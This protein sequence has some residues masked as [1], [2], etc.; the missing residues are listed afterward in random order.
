[1]LKVT[2]QAIFS[3]A[4]VLEIETNTPYYADFEYE[5]YVNHTLYM[6]G[7]KNVF[8]LYR[9]QPDTVY[10]I[11]VSAKDGTQAG[12]CHFKT[13]AESAFLDV[14]RFHA[15]NDGKTECTACL[16]AAI[17]ACPAGG[18]VY[19]PKGRYLTYPLFLTSNVTIYLEKGAVLLGAS[20]RAKY[21]VLPGMIIGDDD[22]E[23]NFG[24]WEGNPIDCFA[25]LITSIGIQNTA[26]IGEGVIDAN[27]QESDWW[28]NRFVRRI[29]W[30][31]RTVFFNRCE[32]ISLVGVTVQNSPSWTVHPYYCKG[33]DV[34]DLLIQNPPDVPNTDGF[35]PESCENVRL[36][37]VKISV[38]D[39]CIAIK[40]GKYYMGSVHHQPCRNLQIRNC[41][42]ERGHGAVVVGSEISSGVYGL[43]V[44]KCLMKD[45]D[46]GLRLKTRRGRGDCSLL[47][48][49]HFRNVHMDGVKTPFVINMFYFCD[50]DGHSE[51]VRS[52][53]KLPV[54]KMTPAVGSL[55]C[56][57][58]VCKNCEVAGGFF[59]GLPE[60][61]I[62]R[63]SMKDFSICFAEDAQPGQAAMM[64]D[65]DDV[66]HLGM[67][68]RNVR[69]LTLENV[70]IQGWRGEPIQCEGVERFEQKNV[71]V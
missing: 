2:V 32:N 24:T 14:T 61:P 15:A 28:E 3:R 6:T 30:R 11:R 20:E 53:E 5:V 18:T 52:K 51:H 17:S 9:L 13:K 65:F 56:E 54:D 64:D 66:S 1:M 36:L 45:T 60:R 26:V 16:Q 23:I 41:L 34:L 40:S 69:C 49:L 22:R 12:E 43:W 62:E 59:Y 37:G 50:P 29:A 38:G 7:N 39:D 10:F 63:I 42:L 46:R 35:D 55:E 47:T 31:P 48:D 19:F 25:S 67:L 57:N 68:A 58:I 71:T 8:S 21:P 27:A 33:V 4:A 44:E 70:T